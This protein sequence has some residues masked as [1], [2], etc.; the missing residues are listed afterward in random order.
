PIVRLWF[1]PTLH[2]VE[3]LTPLVGSSPDD[4][5]LVVTRFYDGHFEFATAKAG[6]ETPLTLV[7]ADISNLTSKLKERAESFKVKM[8]AHATRQPQFA[9]HKPQSDAQIDSFLTSNF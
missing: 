8:D 9:P 2:D 5:E 4:S 7:P 3:Q 1:E 6:A